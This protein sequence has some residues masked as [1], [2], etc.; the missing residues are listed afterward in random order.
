MKL[1]LSFDNGPDPDITPPILAILHAR[2]AHAHFFVLGKH[3]VTDA[4]RALV[5]RELAEGHLVGNHSFT[6]AT[7]LGDDPR[8]DVV[9]REIV[10]TQA[11]L[12]P[13]L[14]P[15][16]DPPWGDPPP[17]RF[18]PFGDGG[19]IGP[20]LLSRAAAAHLVA[21]RYTC[22]LW[23]AVPGDWLD[24]VGW[25][26]Q[27]AS[28][29]E[30]LDHTVLVLHDIPGACLDALDRFLGAA[31]DRGAEIVLDLPPSCTPIRDGHVLS[32][33]APLVRGGSA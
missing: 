16:G 24:P 4:G 10:A 30:A 9:E 12:D 18:R 5:E 29:L 11:L 2:G 25:P 8:G 15:L 27:A 6:H 1:T 26:A 3:V 19:M 23:N 7:P 20:H 28:S 13:L 31:I 17:R 22:V 14:R 21:E 33:L 32:D